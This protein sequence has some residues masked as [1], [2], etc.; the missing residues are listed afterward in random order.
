MS[1]SGQQ[2]CNRRYTE[3]EF[4]GSGIQETNLAAAVL[5]GGRTGNTNEISTTYMVLLSDFSPFATF[6]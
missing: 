6:F 4:Q 5:S 3:K 1:K 2:L